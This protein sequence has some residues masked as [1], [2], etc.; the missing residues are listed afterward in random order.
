MYTHLIAENIYPLNKIRSIVVNCVSRHGS[1]RAGVCQIKFKYEAGSAETPPAVAAAEPTQEERL[2]E[3]LAAQLQL[4]G[5]DT[6]APPPRPPALQHAKV[7][8]YYT[9]HQSSATSNK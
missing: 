2:Q 9:L 1:K 3:Q 5:L 7:R 8:S 4:P 6:S